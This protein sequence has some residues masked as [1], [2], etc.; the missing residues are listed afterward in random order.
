M[1]PVLARESAAVEIRLNIG[2]LA[3]LAAADHLHDLLVMFAGALLR[4]ARHH[5]IVLGGG[6]HHLAAL[7]N[8]VRDGLLHVNVLA[9]LARHDHGDAVPVFRRGHDD[10]VNILAVQDTAKIAVTHRLAGRRPGGIERLGERQ[11]V[12]IRG[13]N[14]IHP[15]RS[16]HGAEIEAALPAGADQADADAVIGAHHVANGRPRG[17]SQ[18]GNTQRRGLVEI[19]ARHLG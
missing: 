1:L 10:G 11:C 12:N 7:V 8:R 5:A 19:P 18:A 16:Y 4:A 17:K 13:G 15:V 6:L 3:D 2:D 14:G 9:R